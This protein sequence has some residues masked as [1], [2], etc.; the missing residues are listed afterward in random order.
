V[1]CCLGFGDV[2]IQDDL[3]RLE[4]RNERLHRLRLLELRQARQG[5]ETPPDII[6]EIESTKAELGMSDLL[7]AE[8]TSVEFADA[9]GSGGQFLILTRL[10]G[11]LAQQGIERGVRQQ[12]DIEAVRQQI[13]A[14]LET[15]GRAIEERI[16]RVETHQDTTNAAQDLARIAGQRRTRLAMF[17]IAATLFVVAVGVVFIV[18]TLKAH[19][20]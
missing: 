18:G 8:K 6:I 15:Q 20:L 9:I 1:F 19:G 2:G 7:L 14:R 10:I 3:K 13:E 5:N 12:E 4:I 16:D 17:A 11:Q